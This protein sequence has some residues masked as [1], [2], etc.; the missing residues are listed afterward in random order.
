VQDRLGKLPDKLL[1]LWSRVPALSATLLFGFQP[2]PQ[3][4]KN[5]GDP[6]SLAGVNAGS[7]LLGMMGNGLMAPRA[8]FVGDVIWL[9]SSSWACTTSWAQLLTLFLGRSATG[10]APQ[11]LHICFVFI[12]HLSCIDDHRHCLYLLFLGIAS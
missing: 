11:H 5:I 1:G 4:A 8:L 12:L 7:L 6:S 9:T 10:C 2:L 3:L